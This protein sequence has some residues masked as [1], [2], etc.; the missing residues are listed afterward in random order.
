MAE[1]R[2]GR[3]RGVLLDTNVVIA[4][5]NRE[6]GA[7]ERIEEAPAG[8]LFVPVVTLGE[9]RF[10]ARVRQGRGEYS[11]DRSL[12]H[13]VGH[14]ALRGGDRPSVWRCQGWFAPQRP[15]HSGER[16]LDLRHRART[17]PHPRREL[18]GTAR[19]ATATRIWSPAKKPTPRPT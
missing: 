13:G 8:S 6:S 10:G 3:P 5:L 11:E 17:R 16:Y 9:M 1:A 7:R 14:S 15:A 18:E 19:P 12:R 2:A 4:A